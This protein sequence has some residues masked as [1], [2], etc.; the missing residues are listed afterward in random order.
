[1][2]RS[3]NKFIKADVILESVATL[4]AL[5]KKVIVFFEYNDYLAFLNIYDMKIVKFDGFWNIDFQNDKV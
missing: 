4:N 5:Q 2:L 3:L 1:M